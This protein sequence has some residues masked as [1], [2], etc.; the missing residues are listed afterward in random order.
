[1]KPFVAVIIILVG[2]LGIWLLY[3]NFVDF[4][5]LGLNEGLWNW[6]ILQVAFPSIA[7]GACLV[8]V[9]SILGFNMIVRGG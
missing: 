8:F 1:M 2:I 3:W 5:T 7:L 9:C 6:T 4:L